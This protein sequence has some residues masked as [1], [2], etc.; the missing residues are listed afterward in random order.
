[1]F[2]TGSLPQKIEPLIDNYINAGHKLNL[3]FL[4]LRVKSNQY[5]CLEI[6][7]IYSLSS[8]K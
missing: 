1:M 6:L 8:D 3:F 4:P 2:R 5:V 7:T